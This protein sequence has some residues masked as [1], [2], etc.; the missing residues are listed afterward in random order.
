MI[1]RLI[2]QPFAGDASLSSDRGMDSHRLLDDGVGL[3][4]AAKFPTD[5]RLSTSY[6]VDVLPLFYLHPSRENDD[7]KSL[8]KMKKRDIE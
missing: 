3:P 5:S 7:E 2:E 1:T 6:F 4:T 8:G